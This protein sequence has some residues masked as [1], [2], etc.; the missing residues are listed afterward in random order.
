MNVVDLQR[1]HEGGVLKDGILVRNVLGIVPMDV[2]YHKPQY[3]YD[4]INHAVRMLRNGKPFLEARRYLEDYL[5]L[6]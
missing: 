3:V 1:I 6:N 4:C 5:K 2:A